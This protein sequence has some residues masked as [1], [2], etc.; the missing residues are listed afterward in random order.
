MA[1]LDMI[2]IEQQLKQ[3]PSAEVVRVVLVD[4]ELD[5]QQSNVAMHAGWVRV[6]ANTDI[7]IELFAA[8]QS[9]TLQ[10]VHVTTAAKTYQAKPIQLN[11]SDKAAHNVVEYFLLSPDSLLACQMTI[12]LGKAAHLE[13]VSVRDGKLKLTQKIH[14]SE[15]S[16][17]K[18]TL[19]ALSADVVDAVTEVLFQGA[20]AACRLY[21]MQMALQ[22]QI[23]NNDVTVTHTGEACQSHI[24]VKNVADQS[25]K[26][27]L[28]GRVVVPK[29][30]QKTASDMNIHSR[31]LSNQAFIDVKPE[32][33]IYADDVQCGH[34]TT[35]GDLDDNLLFYLRSRGIDLDQAKQLLLQAFF[36]EVIA[37]ISDPLLRDQI[38]QT[39]FAKVIETEGVRHA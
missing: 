7:K 18:Q 8:K 37:S 6:D 39:V 38:I 11:L 28:L 27:R 20:K 3:L 4:G 25:G 34:G 14:Q 13:M 24:L 1:A 16:H 10:L 36:D 26:I 23:L 5:L 22:K 19:V 2:E 32:L 30:G 15:S 31:L 17:L 33:E 9:Q 21:A 35:I 29:T 12:T